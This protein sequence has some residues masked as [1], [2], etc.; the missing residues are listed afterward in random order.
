MR[1]ENGTGSPRSHPPTTSAQHTVPLCRRHP[2]NSQGPALADREQPRQQSSRA[3]MSQ[4]SLAWSRPAVLVEMSDGSRL[5]L[6]AAPVHLQRHPPGEATACCPHCRGSTWDDPGWSCL[7]SFRGWKGT[8]NL[9]GCQITS[10]LETPGSSFLDLATETPVLPLGEFGKM[11]PD[12]GETVWGF[13]IARLLCGGGWILGEFS[14]MHPL[15]MFF[16]GNRRKLTGLVNVLG[17]I[18]HGR[19]FSK[20]SPHC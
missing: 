18:K 3:E 13:L 8:G 1:T 19:A 15:I 2:A 20:R 12:Q 11:C 14:L 16:K 10:R 7:Q 4:N 6:E 17:F 5:W 9:S